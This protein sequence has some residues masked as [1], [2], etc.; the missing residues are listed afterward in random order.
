MRDAREDG[1]VVDL[2]AV[3]M[4]DRQH[5]AIANRI[6]EL[7]GMPRGGQ[8]RGFRLAVADHHRH[9][10]VRVVIGRTEGVRHAVAE[11]AA[12]VDRAGGFRRAMAADAA[13]ER[14][15][16]EE[17]AHAFRVLALVRIHLAVK[18]FQIG[19][20]QDAGRAV[21]GAGHEDGVQIVLV[22]Q[23][24]QMHPGKAQAGTRTPVAKQAALDV[25]GLQRLAQQRVV[26][27]E[28]HARCQ[29]IAGAPVGVDLLQF[30]AGER[31]IENRGCR[32]HRLSF[33]AG[34]TS[35]AGYCSPPRLQIRCCR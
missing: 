28:D 32:V 24:V 6:E 7:V 25:F 13:G 34:C 30:L 1:R 33:L 17:L 20:R 22:D 8:R 19:R 29:V 11:F 18:A 26:A 5:C 10:Q 31:G 21:A 3:E 9:Q 16:L 23:P 4:Q 2:V 14:E 12:F 35:G 15:L 27:Q